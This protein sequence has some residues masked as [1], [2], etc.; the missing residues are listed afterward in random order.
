MLVTFHFTGA[1]PRLFCC[2][3]SKTYTKKHPATRGLGYLAHPKHFGFLLHSVL[4]AGADGVPR[5]LIHQQTWTRD[6]RRLGKRK[7][8]RRKET[9]DKESQRW[10]TALQKTEQALP[11]GR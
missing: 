11:A 2:R 3:A 8:R 7:D 10:L 4:L 1:V 9:A 6:P 5:G